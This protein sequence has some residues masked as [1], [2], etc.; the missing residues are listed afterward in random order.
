MESVSLLAN[1]LIERAKKLNTTLLADVMGCTGSLDYRIKPVSTGM[2]FVGT[3]LT[4]SLRP[5]DNL[6]LHQAIYSA[7]KGHV[8]MVDGKGHTNNAYLG[9]LMAS[10]AQAIGIEGIVIDGLVRDK[11]A[12]EKLKFPIYSK[13]F[14][15]NGPFKDGPGEINEVISCGGIRVAPGDLV[16]GDDD[17]VV[18]VPA[19][20]IDEVLRKATEKLS[21]EEKRLETIAQYAHQERPD[22]M[23]LAPKWLENKIKQYQE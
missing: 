22:P 2:E 1:E 11:K 21:Y 8:L 20:L 6:F 3:A 14:N 19:N 10:S 17:G 18:V 16:V 4:V 9:E 13:G 12:L 15:P 23:S 5:G 7:K